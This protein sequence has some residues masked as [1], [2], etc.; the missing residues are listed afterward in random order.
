MNNLFVDQPITLKVI[1]VLLSG[2]VLL[3]LAGRKSISQMTIPEVVLMISIGTLLIQPIK[4][5]NQWV[6]VYG[7]LLLV[8]GMLLISYLQLKF[9]KLRKAING[10]PTVLIQD[11]KID[12]EK[13]KLTKMN[14]DLLE[15]RLRQLKVDH[16][17]DVKT[18]ILETSGDLTILLQ[19]HKKAATK[20]DIQFL[21]DQIHLLHQS[22]KRP[23]LGSSTQSNSL[24]K[25]AESEDVT[26]QPLQ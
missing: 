25:E 12:F 6:A 21:L 17:E 11:G 10:L 23:V 16:I 24:F 9:P 14:T 2:V 5:D 7:G 13:M 22:N 4:T 20:E 8:L 3:R 1:L 26:N 18:A 15:M 19:D